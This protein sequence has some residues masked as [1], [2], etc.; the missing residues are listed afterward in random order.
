MQDHFHLFLIWIKF[1][2]IRGILHV[3]D[4]INDFISISY[5]ITTSI[6]SIRGILLVT[7]ITKKRKKESQQKK[8]D[9][10]SALMKI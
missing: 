5:H 7:R 2:S 6:I 4:Y 1:I 3:N 10:Y 8:D 9:K